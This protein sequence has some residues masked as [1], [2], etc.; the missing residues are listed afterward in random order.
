MALSNSILLSYEK[1]SILCSL[2]SSLSELKKT[3]CSKFSLDSSTSIIIKSYNESLGEYIDIL[4]DDELIPGCKYRLILDLPSILYVEGSSSEKENNSSDVL[5]QDLQVANTFDL[6]ES[7][8]LKNSSELNELSNSVESNSGLEVLHSVHFSNCLNEALKKKMTLSRVLRAELVGAYCRSITINTKYPSS[9]MVTDAPRKI[10]TDYQYLKKTIGTGY[11]SWRQ[12]I[13][14]KLK[15]LRRFDQ[16]EEVKRRKKTSK[17]RLQ[18]QLTNE[19]ILVI[20]LKLHWLNNLLINHNVPKFLDSYCEKLNTLLIAEKKLPVWAQTIKCML[21]ES[22]RNVQVVKEMLVLVTLTVHFSEHQLA[23]TYP[24]TVTESF[25]EKGSASPHLG[26]VGLQ[27]NTLKFYVL[28]EHQIVL[29][30]ST[31][32]EALAELVASYYIFHCEYPKQW[33]KTLLFL[34]SFIFQMNSKS[35]KLP[36]K[37]V[38]FVQ[39]LKNLDIKISNNLDL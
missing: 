10:V 9:I 28:A 36:I 13:R 11:G 20:V 33:K 14:D 12:A 38:N 31:L 25:T 2:P 19:V 35:S 7:S 27:T 23:L 29:Q 39:K 15:N 17:Y 26:I 8:S 37:V 30:L 24:P 5:S 21:D 32:S 1:R 18:Y 4:Q 22:D 34:E 16:S 3:A 6:C